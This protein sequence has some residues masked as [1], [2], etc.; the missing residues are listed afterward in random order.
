[1]T[2][3]TGSCRST[4]SPSGSTYSLLEPFERAGFAVVEL[5]ALTALPEYRNGGLLIDLGVIRPRTALDPASL[6]RWAANW[7]WSGARSRWR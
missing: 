6:T 4:S 2:T 5:D 1:M 3:P 7:W